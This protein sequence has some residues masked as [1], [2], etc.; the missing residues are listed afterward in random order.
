MMNEPVSSIMTRKLLT[1]G[2]NDTVDKVYDLLTK[3]GIHHIPVQDDGLLVGLLTTYDLFKRGL[4]RERGKS[5]VVK[6][7]MTTRLATLEPNAKVGTAAEIFLDHLFHAVGRF[8]L[9][10]LWSVANAAG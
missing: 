4:D 1:V 8:G 7:I 5:V 2:P 9:C 3:K 6:D 10:G